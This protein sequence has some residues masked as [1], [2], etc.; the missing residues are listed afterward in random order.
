M[1]DP[2]TNSWIFVADAPGGLVAE[3]QILFDAINVGGSDERCLS[4]RPAA[5]GIFALQQMAFAGVPAQNF[6]GSGYLE[7]LGH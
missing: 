7:T 3:W 1:G 4:Q 2:K 5:F 6:P